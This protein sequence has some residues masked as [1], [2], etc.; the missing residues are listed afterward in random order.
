MN[1][2]IDMT[3]KWVFVLFIWTLWIFN[4]IQFNIIMLLTVALKIAFYD[5]K[6]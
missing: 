3:T 2:F 1:L 5:V 4:K 6:S